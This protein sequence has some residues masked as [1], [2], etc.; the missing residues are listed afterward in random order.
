MKT[1]K[2][3]PRSSSPRRISSKRLAE[4]GSVPF[5]TIR[6][7]VQEKGSSG[8]PYIRGGNQ[9]AR[10][11]VKKVNVKRKRAAFAHAYHSKERVRFVKS[12]PCTACAA[13]SA[14]FAIGTAGASDNAHTE[15]GEG[16]GLK[17]HYTTIIPLCRGHHTRYDE[18]RTPFDRQEVRD[19]MKGFA[20]K[21]EQA[22]Q[23]HTTRSAS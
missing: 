5:S 2:P 19:A 18:Y 8:K 20:S 16:K 9:N 15:S 1:R 6:P 22:W 23:A 10:K 12:L 13:L 14:L 7:K 21:V 4:E 17:A 11:P 3:L